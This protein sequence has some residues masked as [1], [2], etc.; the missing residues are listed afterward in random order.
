VHQVVLFRIKRHRN[1]MGTSR[2]R[3][4]VKG[5]PCAVILWEMRRELWAKARL[6]WA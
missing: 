3:C 4:A 2:E 6:L 5:T 1:L